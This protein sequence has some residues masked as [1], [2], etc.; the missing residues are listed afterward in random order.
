MMEKGVIFT[1]SNVTYMH[2]SGSLQWKSV[3]DPGT[4]QDPTL[5]LCCGYQL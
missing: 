2:P 4:E 1:V 5:S 3:I